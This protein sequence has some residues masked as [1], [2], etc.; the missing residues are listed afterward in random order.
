M[1]RGAKA[2]STD[3]SALAT[4]GFSIRLAWA[5][6]AHLMMQSDSLTGPDV[7]TILAHKRAIPTFLKS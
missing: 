4:N 3:S 7:A 6:V 2:K 5:E 1:P